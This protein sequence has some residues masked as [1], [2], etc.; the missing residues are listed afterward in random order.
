MH[1]HCRCQVQTT[2]GGTPTAPVGRHG[3]R[4]SRRAPAGSLADPRLCEP[5]RNHAGGL[6]PDI[7]VFE[8]NMGI[9]ARATPPLPRG[10]EVIPISP[11]THLAHGRAHVHKCRTNYRSAGRRDSEYCPGPGSVMTMSGL[12]RSLPHPRIK[13]KGFWPADLNT[14]EVAVRG[15]QKVVSL[16]RDYGGRHP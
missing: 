12:P 10:R 13:P 7:P 8:R 6:L 14:P 16:S 15:I 2:L 1:T 3:G 9:T 5:G 4:T 11:N